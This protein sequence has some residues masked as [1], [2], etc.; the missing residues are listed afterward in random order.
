MT[1]SIEKVHTRAE[2]LLLCPKC[3]SHG[4]LRR[5]GGGKLASRFRC[6]ARTYPTYCRFSF[7]VNDKVLVGAMPR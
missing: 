3:G 2:D 4:S 6:Q 7:V 5:I 1:T